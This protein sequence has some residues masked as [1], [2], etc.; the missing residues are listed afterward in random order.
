MLNLRSDAELAAWATT[1]EQSGTFTNARGWNIK[2]EVEVFETGRL[3]GGQSSEKSRF[4]IATSGRRL[5]LYG[6]V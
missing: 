2:A 5:E 6:S 1:T 4:I 3:G